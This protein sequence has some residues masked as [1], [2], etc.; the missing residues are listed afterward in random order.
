MFQKILKRILD[1]ANDVYYTRGK[2]QQELLCVLRYTKM[3]KCRSEYFAY[4]Q[5][6]KIV[7]F[8]NI[9]VA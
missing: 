9:C 6:Y 1:V 2:S 4:F 7:K 3:T 8:H 5:N